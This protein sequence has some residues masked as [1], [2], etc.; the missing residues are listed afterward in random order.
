MAEVVRQ[1]EKHQ[2]HLLLLISDWMVI[3]AV[4]Q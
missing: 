3:F 2:Q 4:L 1:K